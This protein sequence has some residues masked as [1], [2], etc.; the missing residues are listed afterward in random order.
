MKNICRFIRR[1]ES[2][3]S[4]CAGLTLVEVVIA[5]GVFS[6][7]MGSACFLIARTREMTD[8]ARSHY[9]A[10]NIAKNK[11]EKART[12]DFDHLYTFI[13]NEVVVDQNG[14]LDSNGR[15]RRTTSVTT[16]GPN[17]KKI[18]F[19][20]EMRNRET[21]KFDGREEHVSSY[22]ANYFSRE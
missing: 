16:M 5:I 18:T 7:F 15:W 22:I 21:M 3:E 19:K 20:V 14:S 2:G 4:S 12:H 10:I 6:I 17:L 9:I 1:P 8:V 13:E 11:L